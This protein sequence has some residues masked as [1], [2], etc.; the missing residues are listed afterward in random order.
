MKTNRLSNS[1]FVIFIVSGCSL[2]WLGCD[3]RGNER[4]ENNLAR[5]TEADL[6]KSVSVG[7]SRDKIVTIFG[8]PLNE[9]QKPDGTLRDI[10]NSLGDNTTPGN[11][12]HKFSGFVVFYKSN[13][14]IRVEPSYSSQETFAGQTVVKSATNQAIDIALSVVYETNIVGGVYIDT[15]K[16][17]HL[18]FIAAQPDLEF[19]QAKSLS[20]LT[21][22]DSQKCELEIQLNDIDCE[23]TSRFTATNVGNQVLISLKG[24]PLA[25]PRITSPITGGSL[26]ISRL[27]ESDIEKFFH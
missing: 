16:L 6:Q 20:I 18:G 17:P 14:V 27:A 24:Q 3:R 25:A 23:R 8:L 15:A 13:L 9:E 26:A 22:K 11:W 10:Y 19:H 1:F 12:D 21:N 7:T 5:L 4:P 2:L